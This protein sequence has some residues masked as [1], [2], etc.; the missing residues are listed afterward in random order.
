MKTV[1][2]NFSAAILSAVLAPLICC[3]DAYEPGMAWVFNSP[4]SLYVVRMVEDHDCYFAMFARLQKFGDAAYCKFSV[5]GTEVTVDLTFGGRF[6]NGLALTNLKQ[7]KLT[8]S[9]DRDVVTNAQPPMTFVRMTN[10]Q[11]VELIGKE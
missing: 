5:T 4:E 6:P 1:N 10:A 9:A 7:L 11:A 3:A 8:Y 2:V